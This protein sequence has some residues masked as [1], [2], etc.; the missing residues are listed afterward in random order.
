MAAATTYYTVGFV[1]AGS[2][3]EFTNVPMGQFSDFRNA[4]TPTIW[5]SD[6]GVTVVYTNRSQST[7]SVRIDVPYSGRKGL[8]QLGFPT[9]NI[10]NR[11]AANQFLDIIVYDATPVIASVT[12]SP[13]PAGTRTTLTITGTGFGDHPTVYVAGTAYNLGAP[14]RN[15]QGQDVL[16]LSVTQPLSQAGSSVPLYL[17]SNGAGGQVFVG[18]P[19]GPQAPGS[20]TSNTI[21]IP[22]QLPMAVITVNG[23]QTNSGATITIPPQDPRLQVSASFPGDMAGSVTWQLYARYQDPGDSNTFTEYYPLGPLQSLP[24]WAPWN[25]TVSTGGTVTVLWTLDVGGTQSNFWF[26]ALGSNPARSEILTYLGDDP[27]FLKLLP[28]AE[29]SYRQFDTSG[30]PLFGSPHG[31]GL[32]QIDPASTLAQLYNWQTN[33]DVGR[34]KNQANFAGADS[35]WERQVQQWSDWN[36]EHLDTPIPLPEDRQ[37]A[38]CVFSGETPVLIGKYSFRDAIWIKQYNWAAVNYISWIESLDFTG[39]TINDTNPQGVNYVNRVCSV[40][41]W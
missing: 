5:P 15:L 1:A 4:Q 24:A 34:A 20:P 2:S 28:G 16:S 6:D 26:T 30:K 17:V 36:G 11:A 25:T 40:V 18:E 39:W 27:W 23:Q 13:I 19:L 8:H 3:K 7:V 32:M 31:Y 10:H 12:P 37:E 9:T 38:N 14:T 33:A 35:F 21:L 22:A 29:S 41:P